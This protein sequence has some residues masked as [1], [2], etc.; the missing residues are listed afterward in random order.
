MSPENISLLLSV[1]GLILGFISAYGRIKGFFVGLFK[2][3]GE[4]LSKWR[5][6]RE[7]RIEVLATN[8][9]ALIAYIARSVLYIVATILVTY[10][11]AGFISSNYP[12]LSWLRG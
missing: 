8:P 11:V 10:T 12:T 1:A 3:S 9:N 7:D 4:A 6:L 2:R 5:K